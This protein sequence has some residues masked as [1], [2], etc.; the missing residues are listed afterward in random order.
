MANLQASTVNGQL[1]VTGAITAANPLPNSVIPAGSIL[2]VVYDETNAVTRTNSQSGFQA[3][4]VSLTPRNANSKFVVMGN[5]YGSAGDD[6]HSWLEYRLGGGAWVRN[7]ELN[8]SFGGGAA[9]A[10]YAYH[11]NR[12]E[13]DVQ[14]GYG[15]YVFWSPNTSQSIDV[16][17][18]VSAENTGGMFL[19]I[20]RTED[21]SNAYNNATTKSTLIVMEVAG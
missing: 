20:G 2:Q 18:I 3:L 19:N 9:F 16:R 17:V 8:G 21:T 15:T 5:V 10:D 11:R 14:A 1:D 13:N 12:T 7:T 6:A 4:I